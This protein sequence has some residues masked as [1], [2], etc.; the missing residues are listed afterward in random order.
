MSMAES[1]FGTYLCK[2]TTCL[3]LPLFQERS[4]VNLHRYHCTYC[5]STA[6][7]V[8]RTC[9]HVT[10]VHIMSVLLNSKLGGVRSNYQ[11]LKVTYVHIN[12][13]KAVARQVNPEAPSFQISLLQ[14]SSLLTKIQSKPGKANFAKRGLQHPTSK[15]HTTSMCRKCKMFLNVQ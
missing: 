7:T 11:A 14:K 12:C 4:V 3:C 13:S 1:Y 5:N 15:L 6:I 9:F 2:M 8:T 10:F